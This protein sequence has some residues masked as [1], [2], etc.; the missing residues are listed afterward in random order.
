MIAE[1]S[2]TVALSTS[3][4][5]HC[6]MEVEGRGYESGVETKLEAEARDPLTHSRGT[7]C[8]IPGG[9]GNLYTPDLSH[10]RS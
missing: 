6:K 4:L 2:C 10:H 7:S 8:P 1:Y 9:G 5:V 3:L